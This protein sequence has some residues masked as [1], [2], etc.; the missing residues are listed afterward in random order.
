M[1]IQSLSKRLGFGARKAPTTADVAAR[2]S[3]LHVTEGVSGNW[4]YH[5]S[6]P[7]TNAKALC[8]AHTMYTGVPLSAWGFK[9]HLNETYCTKC[10]KAG[11]A[12][13]LQ[14]GA[15]R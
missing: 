11:A 6:A 10:A 15:E 3:G 9:G 2:T 1:N 8:G 14:G 5:L 7:G 13:L 12:A 4:H